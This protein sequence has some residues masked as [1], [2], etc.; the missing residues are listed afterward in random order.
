MVYLGFHQWVAPSEIACGVRFLLLGGFFGLVDALQYPIAPF[1][2]AILEHSHGPQIFASG[3]ISVDDLCHGVLRFLRFLLPGD[4][5]FGSVNRFCRE[6]IK[7][8]RLDLDSAFVEIFVDKPAFV[9][10]R[11]H[12]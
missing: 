6:Q 9:T 8:G 1:A 2:A 11:E 12:Q 4:E 5:T 3:L 7:T 10:E